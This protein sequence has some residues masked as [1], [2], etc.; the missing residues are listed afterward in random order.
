MAVLTSSEGIHRITL[1]AN[2]DPSCIGVVAWM[3]TG[4]PAAPRSHRTHLL[5]AAHTS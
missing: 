5:I 1:A 4:G 3:Q 2:A